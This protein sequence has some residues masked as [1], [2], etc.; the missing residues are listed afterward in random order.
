MAAF[1]V[2][3]SHLRS[4]AFAN[5]DRVAQHTLPVSALYFLC[6]L[7]H[8]AVIVFF[9]VS[10]YLVGG[11]TLLRALRTPVSLVE[12][13][14]HRIARIY[15]VL[16]PALL[17]GY[18]MDWIGLHL[19]DQDGLY[20]HQAPWHIWSL[21]YNVSDHL[22]GWS[23][24]GNL[25]MLQTIAVPPLGSNGALWSLANEWWYYVA[26]AQFLILLTPRPLALRLGAAA[27]LALL[28]LALPAGLSLLFL[29]WGV[30][31]AAAMLDERWQGIS[32]ALALLAFMAVIMGLRTIN[33]AGL[34]PILTDLAIAAAYALALLSA[35][36]LPL[37]WWHPM[38]RQLARFSYSTYL[39]H[40]P[41]MLLALA[42]T[43]RIFHRG[44]A[45]QPSLA[46]VAAAGGL[47]VVLYG[48][49]W[50]FSML[51]EARTETCRLAMLKWCG[52]APPPRV[53]KMATVAASSQS[54]STQGRS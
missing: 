15:V 8:A 43:N 3:I 48:F 41:A 51:T 40:F 49:A 1:L 37:R 24:L 23:L 54:S 53:W 44:I 16:L 29:V 31:V 35:K 26:F 52:L 30:G 46:A 34:S 20:T 22:T 17:T 25:F 42:A 47:V 39:V 21:D 36:R 5:Y 19:V 6:S 14:S 10:G 13:A 28:V 12:F 27:V 32:P 7:G 9:V 4:I 2:L 38:H 50:G 45:E 33:E 18:G 11:R